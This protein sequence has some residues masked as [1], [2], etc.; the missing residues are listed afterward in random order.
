MKFQK[1]FMLLKKKKSNDELY[2]IFINS[3]K[4]VESWGGELITILPDYSFYH[5]KKAGKTIKRQKYT[6]IF[7][8]LKKTN[9]DFI[10]FINI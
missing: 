2:T 8:I 9:I 7:E 1:T 4:I 5:E 3:K 10:D 6:K